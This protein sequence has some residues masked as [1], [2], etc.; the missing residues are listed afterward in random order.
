VERKL[1]PLAGFQPEQSQKGK[2]RSKRIEGKAHK[3][4]GGFNRALEGDQESMHGNGGMTTASLS[5]PEVKKQ[6][7]RKE[8]FTFPR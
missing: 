7:N 3:E 1:A 2:Q 4:E 8:T 5:Q 6:P